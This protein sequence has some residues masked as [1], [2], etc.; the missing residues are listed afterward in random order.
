MLDLAK[1]DS[2]TGPRYRAIAEE[3]LG[4]IRSGKLAVGTRMPGEL[5]LMKTYK[6]SRHTIREAL[7][8]LEEVRLIERRRGIG[9]IVLASET[10]E[11]YVQLVKEPSE[12]FSYP[13]DSRLR[14]IDRGDVKLNR[15]LAREL[16][17]PTSSQWSCISGLRTF[18]DSAQP[19]CWVNVYVLPEYA[20]GANKIGGTSTPVYRVISE[21]YDEVVQKV[22]VD[23]YASILD[24][25][26]AGFLNVEPGSASLKIC[27]R[28]FGNNGRVF[29]VSLSEHA[30]ANFNYSFEFT[31]S[32]KSADGWAWS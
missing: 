19:I 13:E 18:V 7:R 10:Q 29:E 32:W 11:S 21:L 31:R 24:E 2:G 4:A 25:R 15:A 23:M 20:E 5:D 1:A 3:L 28:Y 27:R 6:V 30:A 14:V 8:V 26:I 22:E 16:K 17:C 9:T 12:L